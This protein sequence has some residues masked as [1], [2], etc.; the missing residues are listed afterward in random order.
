MVVATAGTRR[1]VYGRPGTDRTFSRPHRDVDVDVAGPS[2]IA[3]V[4]AHNLVRDL[5]LFAD[6]V[7]PD[8]VVDDQLVTLLPGETHRFEV[9]TAGCPD[10]AEWAE[11]LTADESVLRAV[12]DRRTG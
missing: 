3:S 2:I 7:D 1:T 11:R 5:C 9:H 8:A 6:R 12:G 10:A 4:T